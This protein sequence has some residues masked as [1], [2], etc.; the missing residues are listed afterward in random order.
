[1]LVS[2][3]MDAWRSGA[4][5]Q[6]METLI[7]WKNLVDQAETAAFEAWR[8]TIDKVK[9]KALITDQLDFLEASKAIHTKIIFLR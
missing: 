8:T 2:E 4:L 7:A 3:I 9:A 5:P 1:M 6:D